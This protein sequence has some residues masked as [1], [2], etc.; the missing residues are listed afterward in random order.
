MVTALDAAIGRVIEALQKK[1]LYDDTIFFFTP[2]VSEAW[3]KKLLQQNKVIIE[4]R[5][6]ETCF[7][8][9][10][11]TKSHPRSLI[12]IFVVH[13]LDSMI[14]L[15]SISKIPSLKLVSVAA[16]AGLSL[17]WSETPKTGFLVTWLYWYLSRVMRKPIYAICE[18]QMRRSACA[19]AESDQHLCF[20]L[21]R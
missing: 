21:L 13:C 10:Q 1:G 20:P 2:D 11:T 12:S 15:V 7:S 17:T 3:K 18:Q 8:H 6:E 14:L 5:H 19:S 16:Q 9:M 4:P